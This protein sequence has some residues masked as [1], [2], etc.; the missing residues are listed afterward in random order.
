[1]FVAYDD[2]L[3]LQI[4]SDHVAIEPATDCTYTHGDTELSEAV[5][6]LATL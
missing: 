1:M 6:S 3:A 5:C 2:V 4:G